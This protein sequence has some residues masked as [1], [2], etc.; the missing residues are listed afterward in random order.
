MVSPA[1]HHHY[2]ADLSV[3]QVVASGFQSTIGLLRLPTRQELTRAQTTLRDLGISQLA[4]RQW[5]ALSFGETRLVLLARALVL[6]PKLLLLD[7]PCDGL[8]PLAQQRFL[9]LVARAARAGAQIIAT[10]HRAEDLPA[11][12]NRILRLHNGRV[13]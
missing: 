2:A 1:L 9:R 7:E 8:A 11:C 6:R 13:I 10:A 12:I 4:A 3:A 5:G